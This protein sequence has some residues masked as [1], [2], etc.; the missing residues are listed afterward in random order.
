[1][2]LTIYSGARSEF[3]STH[4]STCFALSSRSASTAQDCFAAKS[5]A[6]KSQ[7]V[8]KCSC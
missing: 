3:G 5:S 6:L 8:G 4:S 7:V 1:L 2:R